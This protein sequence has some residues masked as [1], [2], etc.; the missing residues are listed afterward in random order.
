MVSP[1]SLETANQLPEAGV[2]PRGQ[3]CG[4][5]CRITMA[6]AQTI[7][8]GR[9]MGLVSL[10]CVFNHP[11]PLASPLIIQTILQTSL[12]SLTQIYSGDLTIREMILFGDSSVSL[13][14][15]NRAV[16]LC[17]V[18]C[19]FFLI[20][21]SQWVSGWWLKSFPEHADTYLNYQWIFLLK[22]FKYFCT[23]IMLCSRELMSC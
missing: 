6:M 13:V 1:S 21:N 8:L 15:I 10:S 12:S 5:S 2:G 18:Y 20:Q 22:P 11:P 23:R 14:K 16:I 9:Y 19:G 4:A 17:R 7:S 3:N